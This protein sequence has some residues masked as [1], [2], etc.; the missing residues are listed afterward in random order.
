M[1]NVSSLMFS[2]LLVVLL[3]VT[4]HV[5]CRPRD[6]MAD[7]T[8]KPMKSNTELITE[9]TNTEDDENKTSEVQET[10]SFIFDRQP[11]PV[12]NS[13]DPQSQMFIFNACVM[14]CT[15]NSTS[16]QVFHFCHREC[17][18]NPYKYPISEDS[19]SDIQADVQVDIQAENYTELD[20]AQH[21]TSLLNEILG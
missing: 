2:T 19:Q 18:S 12:K 11:Q 4:S 1:N 13:S 9:E 20:E 21:I 16:V 3:T 8:N 5:E 6:H 7:R 14:A 15:H 17:L 10:F